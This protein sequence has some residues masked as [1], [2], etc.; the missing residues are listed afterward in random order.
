[1]IV[2][3][4]DKESETIY[5]ELSDKA[6]RTRLPEELWRVAQR[7]LAQLNAAE[8]LRDLATPPGNS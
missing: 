1:M 4:R 7:K 2:S 5:D 3:F 8:S 6:A